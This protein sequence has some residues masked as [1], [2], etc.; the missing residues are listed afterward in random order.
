MEPSIDYVVTKIN[1]FG[2][3]TMMDAF[4]AALKGADPALGIKTAL[5]QAA[6]AAAQSA[7]ATKT[8]RAKFGRARNL[9]ER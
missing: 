7:E 5:Q 1:H 2:D 4:L 3:K 9:G 8:M 6:A